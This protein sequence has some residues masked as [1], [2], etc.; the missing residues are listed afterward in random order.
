MSNN[1]S[2]FFL[3][4]VEFEGMTETTGRAKK[5]KSQFLVDAMTCTEAEAK[6]TI[7]LKGSMLEHE[8]VSVQKSP[9]EDVIKETAVLP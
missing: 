9:I 4:K 5:I 1:I 2:P 8:I 6:M 7:Y 3:V